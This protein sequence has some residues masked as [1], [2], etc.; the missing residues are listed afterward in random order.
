MGKFSSLLKPSKCLII[1]NS[2]FLKTLEIFKLRGHFVYFF[3]SNSEKIEKSKRLTAV[4]KDL[5][6]SLAT[7]FR[8]G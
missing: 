5:T 3:F 1:K 4:E 8:G 6:V 2:I 7:D